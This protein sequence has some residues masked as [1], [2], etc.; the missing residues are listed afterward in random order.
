M[1]LSA[2]CK[3]CGGLAEFAGFVSLPKKTIFS[4][5][6][7]GHQSW[8]D[9]PPVEAAQAQAQ[10]QAQQQQQPQQPQQQQQQQQPQQDPE[11][12]GPDDA[13]K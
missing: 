2:T 8:F 7:C 13:E 6:A 5:P 10:A 1:K 9:G 11:Q 12:T 3:K 4:C